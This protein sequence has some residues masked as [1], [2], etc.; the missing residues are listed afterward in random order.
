MVPFVARRA[1]M[2]PRGQLILGHV[3]MHEVLR[4]NDL[5]LLSYAGHVLQEAG[6]EHMIFDGHTSAMEGSIGALPRRLMVNDVDSDAAKRVLRN[7]SVT[8]PAS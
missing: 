6:I 4:T 8:P 1:I 2:R 3:M 5:V 7:A